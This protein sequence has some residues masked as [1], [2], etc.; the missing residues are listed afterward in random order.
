MRRN[1]HRQK[2]SDGGDGGGGGEEGGLRRGGRERAASP[3]PQVEGVSYF[4][5]A[6]SREWRRTWT[7]A[8]LEPSPRVWG[9]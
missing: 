5:W 6:S 3:R 2:D 7:A 1:I 4:G 8:C 9:D